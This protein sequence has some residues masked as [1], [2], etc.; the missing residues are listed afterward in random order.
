MVMDADVDEYLDKVYNKLLSVA[1]KLLSNV[2]ELR[3]AGLPVDIKTIKLL[4]L[5][6]RYLESIKQSKYTYFTVNGLSDVFNNLN[7][8]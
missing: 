4:N 5:Y 6:I 7:K 2:V 1:D 8:L 3:E